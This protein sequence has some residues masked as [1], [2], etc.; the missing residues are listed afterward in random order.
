MFNKIKSLFEAPDN[1]TIKRMSHSKSMNEIKSNRTENL[2]SVDT[3][4]HNG[5]TAENADLTA[6]WSHPDSSEL[7]TKGHSTGFKMGN[8][9]KSIY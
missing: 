4:L 8:H 3:D 2:N 1:S 7:V 5:K 6:M 9:K